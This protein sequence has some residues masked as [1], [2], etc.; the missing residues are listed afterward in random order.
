MSRVARRYLTT[1]P[2]FPRVS[3]DEPST[4]LSTFTMRKFSPRERG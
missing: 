2:G 1:T 3:G 4:F